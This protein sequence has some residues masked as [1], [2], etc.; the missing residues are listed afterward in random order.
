MPKF[1][2]EVPHTLTKEEAHRRL[3]KFVDVLRQKFQDSVSDLEQTWAGDMLRFKFKSYGFPLAGTIAV[4]DD[5][6]RVDGELPFT[7]M[8]FK[9][10]IESAIKEQ[11]TRLVG[12]DG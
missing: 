2:V 3:D 10:K 12:P 7:A 9:G 11:L 6:L 8:M 5:A 1:N 4:A